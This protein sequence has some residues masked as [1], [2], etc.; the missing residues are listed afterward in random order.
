MYS[1]VRYSC[2]ANRVASIPKSSACLNWNKS[3]VNDLSL[4]L[5]YLVYSNSNPSKKK[6]KGISRMVILDMFSGYWILSSFP[7]F[8]STFGG[9]H[10]L[11]LSTSRFNPNQIPDFFSLSRQHRWSLHTKA[12]PQAIREEVPALREVDLRQPAWIL[13]AGSDHISRKMRKFCQQI[14]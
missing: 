6:R 4:S 5:L 8:L 13:M 3:D 9:F 2:L 12:L 11:L 1:A 10:M 7:T 14:A